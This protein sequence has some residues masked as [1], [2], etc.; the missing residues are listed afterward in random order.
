MYCGLVCTLFESSMFIFVFMWTP[1]LTDPV[2]EKP[3]YGHIFAGFMVMSMCGSQLF[4]LISREQ[5]LE[6]IGRST[7]SVA[8]VCHFVPVLTSNTVVRFLAFMIFEICVGM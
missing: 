7:L 2:A 3:P 1:A 4:V 5:P 6:Q 8:V